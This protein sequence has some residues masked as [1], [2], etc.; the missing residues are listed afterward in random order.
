MKRPVELTADI[1][2]FKN[3][4]ENWIA[5]VGI[6]NDRPYEIFTGKLEEDAMFIPE[7]GDQGSY[8]EG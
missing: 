7:K 1:V 6:Y 2:R 8:P 3:G 5:F 4:E